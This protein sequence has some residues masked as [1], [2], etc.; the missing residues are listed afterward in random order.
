MKN[1]CGGALDCSFQP[2]MLPRR[3]T[4]RSQGGRQGAKAQGAAGA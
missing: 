4:R 1:A 2:V 3:G